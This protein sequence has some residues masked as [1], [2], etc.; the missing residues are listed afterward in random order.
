MGFFIFFLLGLGSTPSKDL[1]TRS[2]LIH[3]SGQYLFVWNRF[4][5]LINRNFTYFYLTNKINRVFYERSLKSFIGLTKPTLN[6]SILI[7]NRI[8]N[9][10]LNFLVEL[11]GFSFSLSILTLNPFFVVGKNEKI[12]RSGKRMGKSHRTHYVCQVAL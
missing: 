12:S 4:F 2:R 8:D 5:G 6:S 9:R 3:Y 11:I 10:T 1:L 7:E